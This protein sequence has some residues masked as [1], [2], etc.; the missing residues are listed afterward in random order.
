[1]PV[2]CGAIPADLLET[3]LFGHIQGAFTGAIRD[4]Q[5]RFQMA[6]GELSF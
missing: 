4:R 2:H 6:Q 3:E 5:G 1:M